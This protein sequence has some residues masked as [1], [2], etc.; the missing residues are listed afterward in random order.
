MLD[1]KSGQVVATVEGAADT[2]D[3]FYDA[4]SKR[5]YM[6]GGDGTVHVFAQRDSDHYDSIGKIP[7]APGARISLFVPELKRYY[8]AV[9]RRGSHGAE[10]LVFDVE[11]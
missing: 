7:T 11:P 1:T 10:I 3:L 6:S 2:D 9:P 5:I 8:V 4:A